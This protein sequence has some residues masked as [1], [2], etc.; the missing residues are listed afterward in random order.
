MTRYGCTPP[1]I[2]TA[3]I[4]SEPTT[5]TIA[6]SSVLFIGCS[7]RSVERAYQRNAT[8]AIGGCYAVAR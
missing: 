8:M 6:S 2:M 3:A 1:K 5:I 4:I 7:S